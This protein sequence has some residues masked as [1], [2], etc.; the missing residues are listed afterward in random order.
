MNPDYRSVIEETTMRYMS[1]EQ[2]LWMGGG[3]G[4]IMAMC[5]GSMGGVSVYCCSTTV[6][7]VMSDTAIL[8]KC[9]LCNVAYVGPAT[10]DVATFGAT[11]LNTAKPQITNFVCSSKCT[12]NMHK[13]CDRPHIAPHGI[14]SNQVEYN[15]IES[16]SSSFPLY[17]HSMTFDSLYTSHPVHL[18]PRLSIY[19]TT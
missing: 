9:L 12:R 14:E 3:R 19:L 8:L 6:L 18:C 10:H 1:G 16:Q 13:P 5:S 2:A 4:G 17:A 7:Y 11:P 15:Q